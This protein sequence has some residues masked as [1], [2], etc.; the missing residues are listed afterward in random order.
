MTIIRQLTSR[1][2]A[3]N[4]AERKYIRGEIKLIANQDLGGHVRIG[5]AERQPLRFLLVPCCDAREPKVRDFET[6]VGCYE[7]VFTL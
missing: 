1:N 4:N 5:A 3:I 6:A 7:E 2:F